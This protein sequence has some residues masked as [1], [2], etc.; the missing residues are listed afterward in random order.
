[1]IKDQLLAS[2]FFFSIK[3]AGLFFFISNVLTW[4]EERHSKSTENGKK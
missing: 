2:R 3:S 1:M 4:D